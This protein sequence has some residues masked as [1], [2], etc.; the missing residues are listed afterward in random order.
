MDEGCDVPLCDSVFWTNSPKATDYGKVRVV[1]QLSRALRL[2]DGKTLATAF[3]WTAPDNLELADALERLGEEDGLL[4]ARVRVVSGAYDRLDDAG[5]AEKVVEV[6]KVDTDAF[7]GR[8]SIGGVDF[9]EAWSRFLK[10]ITLFSNR[11]GHANV[12]RAYVSPSGY[13]LGKTIN[14]VRCKDS[15]VNN[16][17]M[18]RKALDS[19]GFIWNINI[20][21]WNMF[22]EELNLYKSKNG[23]IDVPVNYVAFNGYKVGSAVQNARSRK[24]TY[25][26]TRRA[27]LD[28]IGFIW[29]TKDNA[30]DTFLEEIKSFQ[31]KESHLNVPRAY[32]STT[33]YKLGKVVNSVRCRIKDDATRKSTLDAMGFV[34]NTKDAAF[35][36][37]I[38]ELKIY[39]HREGNA[40]VQSVHVTP[41]G[42]KLGQYSSNIRSGNVRSNGPRRETLDSL[43]FV[44]DI[45]EYEWNAV[46]SNLNDFKNREGHLN[47]SYSYVSPNGYKLGTVITGIRSVGNFI[48]GREDRRAILDE[49][50]FVWSPHDDKWKQFLEEIIAFKHTYG[51]SLVPT[52]YVSPSDYPLGRRVNGVRQGDYVKD[53]TTRIKLLNDLGFVWNAR[54]GKDTA[55]T[56]KR[57][58]ST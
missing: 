53:N 20:D 13:N 14:S 57:Q 54:K 16:N 33:G 19:I 37:F 50:G 43:G 5:V 47:I 46:V 36:K 39:I 56:P 27:S 28:A 55:S 10:E 31:S 52:S 34:W 41:S 17:E 9:S 4:G 24:I 45:G 38:E 29:N 22:L 12:P 8:F 3:I 21:R 7:V 35:D 1:Q 30:W 44:W 6:E 49:I 51:N 11:E 2:C 40:A 42:Y 32:V 26:E 58:P 25:D 15:L 48:N 23:H 18:R